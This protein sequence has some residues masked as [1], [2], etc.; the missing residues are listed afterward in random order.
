MKRI[1]LINLNKDTCVNFINKI[2]NLKFNGQEKIFDNKC[3]DIFLNIRIKNKDSL[4]CSIFLNQESEKGYLLKEQDLK[5]LNDYYNNII[6]KYIKKCKN[7]RMEDITVDMERN[8][9]TVIKD[10]ISKNVLDESYKNINKLDIETTPIINE[11]DDIMND[12]VVPKKEKKEKLNEIHLNINEIDNQKNLLKLRTL[13]KNFFNSPIH[14]KYLN[15][16][17][18]EDLKAIE[19]MCFLSL[20]LIDKISLAS[21]IFFNQVKNEIL[22]QIKEFP[23]KEKIKI[24]ICIRSH[25]LESIPSKIK[26]QKMIELPEYSPYL[27][28]EIMYRNIIKSLDTNSKLNFIFKQ[29]NSGGGFD[30]I[31]ND[32]CYYLKMIPLIVIKSHLLNISQDYFFIYSNEKS[33]E[34]SYCEALSGIVSINEIKAFG[35]ENIAYKK[36]EDN[37]IKV[38]LINIHEKGGH[39][40]YGKIELSPRLLISN[41]LNIHDNYFEKTDAGESGNAIEVILFGGKNIIL[42]LLSCKNLKRLSDYKLFAEKLGSKI[43]REEIEKIFIENKISIDIT[44]NK[45]KINT[46]SGNLDG[47]KIRFLKTYGIERVKLLKEKI[48]KLQENIQ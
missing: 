35:S 19:K 36:N 7:F 18:K 17:T 46:D 9:S 45:K 38:G 48:N 30:W 29:L 24:I 22:N 6:N 1:C 16:P 43:L 8:F 42:K 39:Q 31:N 25:L 20:S 44:S 15:M 47:K 14:K 3:C 12:L 37:S 5:I 11:E 40:K 26:L 34:M 23:I 10:Y 33:D 2:S 4:E 41:E 21:V 13:E 32:Y 28:G 27:C